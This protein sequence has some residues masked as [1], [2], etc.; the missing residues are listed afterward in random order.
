MNGRIPI[1]ARTHVNGP[2]ANPLYRLLR[3]E[4][5]GSFGKDTPGGE[6]LYA[7][8]DKTKRGPRH[9][10]GEVELHEVPRRPQRRR[11]VSIVPR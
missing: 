1:F 6:K 3:A 4:Q 11:R 7:H 9:G 10:R 2:N 5:P 8:L